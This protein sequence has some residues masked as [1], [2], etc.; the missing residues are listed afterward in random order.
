MWGPVLV[1]VAN[2]L[3]IILMLLV[4]VFLIEGVL[5]TGR[6]IVCEVVGMIA[7]GFGVLAWD[8]GRAHSTSF[9]AEVVDESPSTKDRAVK[10]P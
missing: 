1:S 9:I 10:N 3:T 2:L 8:V 5:P 7:G 4:D 6:S